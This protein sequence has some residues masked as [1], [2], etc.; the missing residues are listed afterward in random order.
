MNGWRRASAGL[1]L[2]TVVV[3]A[4]A[5]KKGGEAAPAAGGAPAAAAPVAFPVSDN[6]AATITGR[7]AFTGAKPAAQ[8]IDMS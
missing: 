4:T 2:G 1:V 8:R 6:D 7:V 5:C 3:V